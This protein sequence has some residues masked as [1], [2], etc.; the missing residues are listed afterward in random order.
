[1]ADSGDVLQV[2]FD[3]SDHGWHHCTVLVGL[4]TLTEELQWKLT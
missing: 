4:R 3:M 2:S 1:M